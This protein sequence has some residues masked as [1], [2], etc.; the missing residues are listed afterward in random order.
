MTVDCERAAA[1]PPVKYLNDMIISHSS[2]R[3]RDFARCYRMICCRYIIMWHCS[4]FNNNGSWCNSRPIARFVGMK[5]PIATIIHDINKLTKI[6]NKTEYLQQRKLAAKSDTLYT[7]TFIPRSIVISSRP[8]LQ[9]INTMKRSILLLICYAPSK[10]FGTRRVN[11]FG[12]ILFSH[13]YVVF[14]NL[15]LGIWNGLGEGFKSNRYN[16]SREVKITNHFSETIYYCVWY[17]TTQLI[18][19]KP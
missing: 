9:H 3:L 12:P 10:W 18:F 17:S 7:N 8:C 16:D 6:T 19:W 4:P 15:L 11:V 5:T 14:R 2:S 13:M 1:T